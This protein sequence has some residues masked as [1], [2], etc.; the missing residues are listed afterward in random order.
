M[1]NTKGHNAAYFNNIFEIK[2]QFRF[3]KRVIEI[4]VSDPDLTEMKQQKAAIKKLLIL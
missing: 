1:D 3:S 2:V 4:K